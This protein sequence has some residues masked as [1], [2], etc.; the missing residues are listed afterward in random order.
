MKMMLIA[1]SIF[2]TMLTNMLVVISPLKSNPYQQHIME[3]AI[4]CKYWKILK[5]MDFL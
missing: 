3:F 1:M 5:Q 4:Q 2:R